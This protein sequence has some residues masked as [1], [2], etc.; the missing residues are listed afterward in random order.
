MIMPLLYLTEFWKNSESPIL[1]SHNHLRFYSFQWKNSKRK[2]NRVHFWEM[3]PTL[4]NTNQTE[5][6]CSSEPQILVIHQ[7]A[8]WLLF[9]IKLASVESGWELDMHEW[10][11]YQITKNIYHCTCIILPPETSIH[12]SSPTARFTTHRSSPIIIVKHLCSAPT[13]TVSY[14]WQSMTKHWLKWF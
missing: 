7:R 6:S 5:V 2:P 11:E 1:M 12:F 13:P 10:V 8:A 3:W 14:N 4:A 9:S